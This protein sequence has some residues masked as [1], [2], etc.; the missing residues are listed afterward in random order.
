MN[1]EDSV[2]RS[3]TI[4]DLLQGTWT[5]LV[6]LTYGA[7]L[8]FFESRLLGRL[9]QI[10][11]RVVLADQ[12]RLEDRL[13]EAAATGQRL[14][15]ANRTYV[16][17]P[18]RHPRAAHAKA[19]L[20]ANATEGLLLIGSGN[21]GPDGYAS[22]GEL[23]HVFA[24]DD[25]RRE[26]L[27]DFITIRGLVDGLATH[28]A[29]DPPTQDM[30]QQVWSRSAWLAEPTHAFG[31]VRHNLEVSL[32]EQL[33]KEVTWKVEQMTTYAP[34]HD[35]DCAA[36][37]TLIERF[38]P[39]RL[40]VLLGRDTSVD[41]DRLSTVIA[42]I[43]DSQCLHVVIEEDPGTYLHAKWVHLAGAKQEALLSGSAN[44]SQSAMLNSA[45]TGNVELGVIN[46][47][48]RGDYDYLYEPLLLTPVD[49]P[50]LLGVTYEVPIEAPQPLT[51]PRLLWSRLDGRELTL[52]FDRPVDVEDAVV[53][54]GPAGRIPIERARA[55]GSALVV[56]LEPQAAVALAEGGPIEVTFGEEAQGLVT[57]PYHLAAL[58]SRLERATDRDLLS[59]AGNL[60]EADTEL[61]ELLQAL[62]STL[63]FDPVSA[64]R[65]ATP[66]AQL[67]HSDGDETHLRW[68]DLDWNRI[69]R[70]PRY[71]GYHFRGAGRGVPPTEIQVLLAAISGKLG[72]LG[73]LDELGSPPGSARGSADD[74]SDLA[75]PG[76]VTTDAETNPDD[77]NDEKPHRRLSIRTRTRMAFNRFVTRYAAATRDQGFIDQLGPVLAV[78]NATI[79]NHLLT[80]LL[81]REIVEP[82][83]AVAAQI[84]TWE[85][86]WG[87]SDQP[88]IL[89]QLSDAEREAAQH[90]LKEA[91]DR[92]TTLVALANTV[93]HDLPTDQRITLRDLATR[94]ITDPLFGLDSQLI[95]S[96]TPNPRQ[97]KAL[98]TNLEALTCAM[99][100]SEI[101]D[102]VVAPLGITHRDVEWR[103]EEVMRADPSVGRP[104]KYRSETMTI[105][106]GSRPKVGVKAPAGS[107]LRRQH[108]GL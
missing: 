44:L 70:D 98:L 36:L 69:R 60:P 15:M 2:P 57:W 43:A 54:L 50:H 46:S 56:R 73:D 24:Y 7:N 40:R 84:A 107:R 62:E 65:V 103:A 66:T 91:H 53:L 34:F 35:P 47:G 32:A 99:S 101:A 13:L 6:V 87:T 68:Q 79:F 78:H 76:D 77:A 12:H 21:L 25:R 41:A 71:R 88:G 9:A 49:S 48:V 11:L 29:L 55:D 95:A 4:P 89:A 96:A 10:P 27:P 16:A 74:E 75:E 3:I 58:L 45:D 19:I 26:H 23:W 90:V 81:T 28:G 97:G 105:F 31:T 38:R 85:M 94:L 80:Q 20:L 104:Y 106:R 8:G 86:L 63:I 1:V 67:D 83:R 100:D 82:G 37:A 108:T 102:Y 30:L 42:A 51:A 59:T 39:R 22:S 72:D 33:A 17:G 92:S 52:M 61:F 64:W 93:D 5:S 18:I 14:R